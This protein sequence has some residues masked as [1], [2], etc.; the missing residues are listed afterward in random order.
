VEDDQKG[1]ES[2]YSFS[3]GHP[4]GIA[5][6][7]SDKA[8]TLADNLETQ[9]QPVT[10]PSFLA[11]IEMVGV[12]L[13]SYFLT[14][15]SETKM[16]NT[17]EVQEAIRGLKVSKVPGPKGIAN[18]TLKHLPQ[19]AVSLL[20]MIFKAI[21][22]THH[23]PSVWKHA[24]VISILKPVRTQHFHHPNGPLVSWTRLVNFWKR[25]Y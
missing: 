12:A 6:S 24:R 1:N 15:A 23:F 9:F 13:R 14:P 21:L 25:P 7:D 22:L 17:D 19:R 3:P 4:E 20:V 11:V 8:E 10:D 16:T 18:R 2:S 5:V